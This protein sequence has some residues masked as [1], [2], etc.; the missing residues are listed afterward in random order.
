MEPARAV[1]KSNSKTNPTA[2]SNIVIDD[3]G[4][5]LRA[6]SAEGPLVSMSSAGGVPNVVI[7]SNSKAN[8]DA[9]LQC[10]IEDTGLK[11]ADEKGSILKTLKN[12]GNEVEIWYDRVVK[13]NNYIE[14]GTLV[15]RAM[16]AS[17]KGERYSA[18]GIEVDYDEDHENPDLHSTI[19]IKAGTI[20][21]ATLNNQITVFGNS[22]KG[23]VD[24][25]DSTT[26]TK[27]YICD[28]SVIK[29]LVE[30]IKAIE[31]RLGIQS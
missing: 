20:E 25:N 14:A 26:W 9:F 23:I 22:Y 8:A 21:L 12:A 1:I 19:T 18:S 10:T 16:K 27:E 11:V 3:A 5:E 31:T 17:A 30:R 15:W 29:S 13:F 28:G 7:K 4:L 6:A 24:M 2:I